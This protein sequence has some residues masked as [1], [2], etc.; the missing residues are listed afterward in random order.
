MTKRYACTASQTLWRLPS[1][2]CCLRR[3]L[4]TFENVQ[5]TPSSVRDRC[6]P[7]RARR[8][9]R[10]RARLPWLLGFHVLQ[11]RPGQGDTP[12]LTRTA[13]KLKVRPE[14][15]RRKPLTQYD[16]V[17]RMEDEDTGGRDGRAC[18]PCSAGRLPLKLQQQ[19]RIADTAERPAGLFPFFPAPRGG[20]V[21]APNL[22][23]RVG[24]AVRG[25]RRSHNWGLEAQR[26]L[27]T[28]FASDADT[29]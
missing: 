3:R 14:R 16:F 29:P 22:L 26:Q 9:R 20:G 15:R 6:A 8:T 24:P 17:S 7:V 1:R 13:S 23:P 2:P 10:S 4:E 27:A 5:V 12:P 11:R 21:C 25:S 18:W 28:P 19:G